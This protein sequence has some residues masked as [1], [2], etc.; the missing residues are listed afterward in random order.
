MKILK[1]IAVNVENGDSV[2]VKELTKTAL[3]Q[4]IAA[5]EILNNGLV[6][7]MDVIGI[8]F[9]NNEVFIPEVLIATRAMKAGMDIIRPFLTNERVK[10]KAKI[11][12]GTIKGDLHDIGK[13]I[14]GMML[15]RE[16][17]EIVDI[18]IDVP[19]EKFIKAIKKENPD[20]IGMSALLTTTMAYMREVI[21]AVEKAKLKQNVKIIIGGAPI[22]QAFADEIKADGFAPE[23][24]S[25]VEL[26]KYL[27]KN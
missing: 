16:G 14:V 10:P 20:I 8:K 17:Y 13:K 12:M 22:T 11:V 19:K 24:A 2:S 4:K 1:E 27:L 6:K 15:E 26:V 5:E 7:G 3:S 23:A 21:E 9:K 18:G 25:A